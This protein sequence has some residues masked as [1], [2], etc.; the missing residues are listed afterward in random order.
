MIQGHLY[1]TQCILWVNVRLSYQV[2]AVAVLCLP[3]SFPQ[4]VISMYSGY[5][6]PIQL[7]LKCSD[8]ETD[9]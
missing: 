1:E 3:T 8:T 4:S 5:T 7:H 9:I 2:C 6:K